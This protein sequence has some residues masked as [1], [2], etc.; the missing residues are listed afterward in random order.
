MN[1][2]VKGRKY[3]CIHLLQIF[4]CSAKY[5]SHVSAFAVDYTKIERQ[6]K[7]I[8]EMRRSS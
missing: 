8:F 4:I 5:V 1:I 7:H 6:K 3:A 2:S